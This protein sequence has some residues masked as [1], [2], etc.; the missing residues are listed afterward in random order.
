M[1]NGIEPENRECTFEGEC[2]GTCP[3]CDADAARI[4][5]ELDKKR[6]LG[7][8]IAV[9]GLS[10]ALVAGGFSGCRAVEPLEG[11]VPYSGEYIDEL[12]GDIADDG[13]PVTD[14]DA[15]DTDATDTDGGETEYELAGDVLFMPDEE[16]GD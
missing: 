6:G 3:A 2:K 7:M 16:T 15:T 10:A 1:N 5:N 13:C 12:D 9:A 4:Q 8:K 11:D 14:T